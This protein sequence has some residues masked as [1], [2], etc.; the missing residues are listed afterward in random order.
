[1]GLFSK[2]EEKMDEAT[3]REVSKVIVVTMDSVPGK[4]IVE[5]VGLVKWQA[6]HVC[7]KVIETNL[8]K[9]AYELGANAVVGVKVYA[10][11]PSVTTPTYYGTAVI[12]E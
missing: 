3:E 2:K 10:S 5:V 1:M 4:T 8:R 11:G 7:E 9:K 6:N 12:V